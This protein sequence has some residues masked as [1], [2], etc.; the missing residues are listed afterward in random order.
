PA[1]TKIDLNA[2]YNGVNGEIQWQPHY[3]GAGYVDLASFF[4]AKDPALAYA[5]VYVQSPNDR[6]AVLHLGAS[7]GIRILLNYQEVFM[8]NGLRT[9]VP[10]QHVVPVR[11]QSGWNSLLLKISHLRGDWGFYLEITDPTGKPIPEL[12]VALKR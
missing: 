9:A 6:P 5:H 8:R 2:R 10:G 12:K 3:S 1:E 4:S 11:L 7:E